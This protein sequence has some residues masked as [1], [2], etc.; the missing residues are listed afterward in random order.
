MLCLVNLQGSVLLTV[1]S[2]LLQWTVGFLFSI[3][4]QG[5][6][7]VLGLLHFGGLGH[8][9]GEISSSNLGNLNLII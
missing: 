1:E 7:S 5:I 6:N 9:D 2:A 3:N 8:V 4:L